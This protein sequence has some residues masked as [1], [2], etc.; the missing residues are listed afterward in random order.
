MS[1]TLS[2]K[3]LLGFVYSC[4][5]FLKFLRAL[6]LHFFVLIVFNFYFLCGLCSLISLKVLVVFFSGV[7]FCSLYCIFSLGYFCFLLVLLSFLVESGDS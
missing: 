6:A 7:F 4:F 3:Y 5:P 1:S 2:Y